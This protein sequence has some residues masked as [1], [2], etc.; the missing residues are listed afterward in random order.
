MCG[1]CRGREGGVHTSHSSYTL[2]ARAA[3]MHAFDSCRTDDLK[4]SVRVDLP[5]VPGAEPSLAVL[6]HVKVLTVPGLLLVVTHRYIRATDHNFP[7][8][9]GLVRAVVS[10]WGGEHR[11]QL[12]P[13]RRIICCLL[14]WVVAAHR[15]TLLPVLQRNLGANEWSTDPPCAVVPNCKIIRKKPQ[16]AA[17]TPVKKMGNVYKSTHL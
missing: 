2:H 3:H 15:L 12:S 7:P 8:W 10:T 6:V 11:P 16:R 9:V 14:C 5:D 13:H 4:A 1:V 17:E